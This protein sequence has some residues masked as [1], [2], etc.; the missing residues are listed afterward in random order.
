[1]E[2]VFPRAGLRRP[3][4]YK[5]N[6]IAWLL[7][8]QHVKVLSEVGGRGMVLIGQNLGLVIRGVLYID[9][10]LLRN[11][12]HHIRSCHISVALL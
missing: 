1:M 7:I 10:H 12:F 5:E 6:A 9:N 2:R 3:D 4:S 8:R 11:C